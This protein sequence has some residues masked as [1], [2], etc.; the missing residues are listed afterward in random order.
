MM[1]LGHPR[2]KSALAQRQ[3]TQYGGLMTEQ[4]H[5]LV[6]SD[7]ADVLERLPVEEGAFRTGRVFKGDGVTLIRLSF[8]EGEVMREHQARFPILV[9]TITGRI[10][11]EVEGDSYEMPAGA[12]IH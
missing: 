10:V 6:F 9:Q 11:F 4:H 5:S 1:G 8:A 12:M 3:K 7:T 2:G